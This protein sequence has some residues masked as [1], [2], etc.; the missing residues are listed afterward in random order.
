MSSEEENKKWHYLDVNRGRYLCSEHGGFCD[1]SDGYA[2]NCPLCKEL[3]RDKE[4]WRVNHIDRVLQVMKNLQTRSI[5]IIQI[6]SGATGLLGLFSILKKDA[7]SAYFLTLGSFSTKLLILFIIS[8]LFSFV[9]YFLS[10]AHMKTTEVKCWG[11]CGG[12]KF[13]KKTIRRWE[14]HIVKRL[15]WFESCHAFSNILLAF[16]G[17]CIIAF[18]FIQLFLS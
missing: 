5:R 6:L 8:F 10:I 13:S 15:G 16:S 9:L 12:T 7:L 2:M 4:N 14:Q 1:S 3:E 18:L 17:L 11:I